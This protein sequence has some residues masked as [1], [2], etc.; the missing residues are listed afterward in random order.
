MANMI[1]I[2]NLYPKVDVS[3][4]CIAFGKYG[5]ILSADIEYD[6]NLISVGKGFVHFA[7]ISSA[8]IAVKEMNEEK[9]KLGNP[10]HVKLI[11]NRE[12]NN[13]RNSVEPDETK[14]FVSNFDLSWDECD[15][16]KEFKPYGTIIEVKISESDGKSNG[17]GFVKFVESSS[18]KGAIEMLNGKMINNKQLIVEPFIPWQLREKQRNSLDNVKVMDVEWNNLHVKNL[19]KDIK[20]DELKRL[21]QN[22]GS[23]ISVKVATDEKGQSKGFGFVCFKKDE[24]AAKAREQMD[25]FTYKSKTLEIN[26]NQ[27]KS[28]RQKYLHAIRKDSKIRSFTDGR[29]KGCK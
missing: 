13:P 21:F 19:R 8:E 26:F 20:E 18:A 7:E 27:K 4:L 15:M 12:K 2:D 6:K 17:Y 9:N 22:F 11:E 28:A 10:I 5:R 29:E 1:M 24:D 23:I 14:I 3:E 25:H 16:L